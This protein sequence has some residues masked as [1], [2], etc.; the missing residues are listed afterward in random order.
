MKYSDTSVEGIGYAIP[1]S[2]AMIIIEKLISGEKVEAAN[3]GYLGIQGSD[4]SEGVFVRKVFANSAAEKAGICVGDIIVE[5]EGNTISTMSQLKELLSYYSA[6]EEVKFVI[7]H[8]QGNEYVEK[9][10]TVTLGDVSS[11]QQ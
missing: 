2:D 9:E 6:G 1:I 7:Y 11:V 5:F 8:A 4:T 10:I 3:T